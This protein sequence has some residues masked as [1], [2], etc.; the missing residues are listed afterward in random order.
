MS[1]QKEGIAIRATRLEI[2]SPREVEGHCT[3]FIYKSTSDART[4]EISNM[5]VCSTWSAGT[6]PLYHLPVS[7]KAVPMREKVSTV[8]RMCLAFLER[9]SAYEDDV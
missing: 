9:G 7:T 4:E 2:D 5:Y 3:L 8:L 6:K 1:N